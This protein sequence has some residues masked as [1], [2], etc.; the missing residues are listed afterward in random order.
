MSNGMKQSQNVRRSRGHRGGRGP[1]QQGRNSSFESNGPDGK[2]RGNA[3]QVIDKYQSL[4]RDALISGDRIA[5]ENYFQH[6]EHY[7]RVL[8]ANGDAKVKNTNSPRRGNGQDDQE[9]S[10]ASS[11]GEVTEV[12]V[13]VS[14][15]DKENSVV[16]PDPVETNGAE[17]NTAK[18][19][20]D[21]LK[22]NDKVSLVEEAPADEG[23]MRALGETNE[24]D[25]AND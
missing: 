16:K 13:E 14:E 10:L 7:S 6:A 22:S 3:H 11:V 8:S 21:D 4:G 2:I 17:N 5:A 12:S 18:N 9:R 23:L 25:Q 15:S 24:E 19:S 20:D 1:N